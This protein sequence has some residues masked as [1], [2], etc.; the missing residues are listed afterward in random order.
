MRSYSVS[1]Y[2]WEKQEHVQ[3]IPSHEV[4]DW[5]LTS[6]ASPPPTLNPLKQSNTPWARKNTH[7]TEE[8]NVWL[9]SA[10]RCHEHRQTKTDWKSCFIDQ[11]EESVRDHSHRVYSQGSNRRWHQVK[12]RRQNQ[13][14]CMLKN[15]T[16]EFATC[17]E[18]CEK[19]HKRW[20]CLKTH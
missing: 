11:W 2:N 5:S 4:P 14:Q 9:S 17:R 7:E 8:G 12:N 6:T 10:K 1:E 16:A 19:K 18:R 3:L 20:K 13:I 15:I